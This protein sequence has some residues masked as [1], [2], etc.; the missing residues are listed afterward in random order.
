[1]QI[2][3]QNLTKIRIKILRFVGNICILSS[4]CYSRYPPEYKWI[5]VKAKDSLSHIPHL[6]VKPIIGHTKD[7]LDDFLGLV[8]RSTKECGEVYRVNLLGRW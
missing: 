6:P 7:A 8:S 3:I 2:C 5:F 4:T 1:M